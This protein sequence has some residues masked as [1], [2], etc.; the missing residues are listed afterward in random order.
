VNDAKSYVPSPVLANDLLFVADDRGI[1]HCF[2]PAD[3]EHLWRE[4]LGPHFSASLIT[5]E[6]L[7]Y[8]TADDGETTIMRAAREPIVLQVNELGERVYA[9][10]AIS[11]GELFLRGTDHLFCISQK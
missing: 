4:R 7:V 10:P 9:S 3:G 1:A 8:F 6:G 11:Q 2:D 5:A